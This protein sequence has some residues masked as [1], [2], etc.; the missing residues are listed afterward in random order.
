[1]EQHGFFSP[2]LFEFLDELRT[3]NERAWFERNK[4]RFEQSVREPFSRL[5]AALGPPL[6][7]INPSLV[8]DPRP[9]GGSM[10]RIY[11]DLRFSRDKS[12]YKTSIAAHFSNVRGKDLPAPAYYLHFAPGNSGIGAGMWRPPAAALKEIRDA[13][14]AEPQCWQ[15][16]IGNGEFRAL[17]AM[18]GEALKRPPAGYDHNHPLIEDLKRKDFTIHTTLTNA[19]VLSTDL[20]ETIV[21]CFRATAPFMR[22]LSDAVGVN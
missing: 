10:M 11:R 15:R 9:A 2:D 22:F 12:P 8:A 1:M 13:I 4:T 6:R 5:I 3:H 19:Q 20:L 14:V 21:A 16:V 17:C 18:A 7:K